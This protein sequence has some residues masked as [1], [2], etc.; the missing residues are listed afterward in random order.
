MPVRAADPA[1]AKELFDKGRAALDTGNWQEACRLFRASFDFDAS[2]G[3]LLNIAKCHEHEQRWASA[4]STYERARL[5]NRKTPTARRQKINKYISKR[6]ER[7]SQQVPRLLIRVSPRVEGLAVTRNG[8]NLP[9]SGLDLSLP[10]DPG[11][12]EIVASAPGQKVAR[13]TIKAATGQRVVVELV[14]TPLAPEPA[15]GD[16]GAA[17]R[18][19]RASSD[20]GLGQ[21]QCRSRSRR[22]GIGGGG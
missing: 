12:I 8:E 3:A 17:R 2:V 14:L 4:L 9:L 7:A 22:R 5:L 20:L 11:S 19:R 10:V 13:Q 16:G 21:R 6:V 1:A 18:G 15:T